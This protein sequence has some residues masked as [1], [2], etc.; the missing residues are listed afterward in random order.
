MA[1]EANVRKPAAV[2]MSRV[3]FLQTALAIALVLFVA[4]CSTVSGWFGGSGKPA[5][6]PADLVEIKAVTAAGPNKEQRRLFDFS[7][8]VTLKRP[9]AQAPAGASSAPAGA[10][11]AAAAKSS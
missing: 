2:P 8:R 3:G 4:G 6:K 10:S 9:Q 1:W 5:S 11:S 7:M